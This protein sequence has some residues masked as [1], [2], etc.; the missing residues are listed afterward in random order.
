VPDALYLIMCGT[1]RVVLDEVTSEE[2]AT[3]I[4]LAHDQ[5]HH[6]TPWIQHPLEHVY[7][8]ES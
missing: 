7:Q 8:E 3:D 6:C 4:A 1:V 5:V 2:L